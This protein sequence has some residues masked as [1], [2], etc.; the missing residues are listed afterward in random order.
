[1]REQVGHSDGLFS[2]HDIARAAEWRGSMRSLL[3]CTPI[4][5][6]PALG[7]WHIERDGRQL[8]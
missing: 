2:G 3:I 7:K 6:R 4:D 5:D 8:G 1:M